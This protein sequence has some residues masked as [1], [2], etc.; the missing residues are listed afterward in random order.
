MEDIIRHSTISGDRNWNFIKAYKQPQCNRGF[1]IICLF[2][3]CIN[4][5]SDVWVVSFYSPLHFR[6]LPEETSED[7]RIKI[8]A[9]IT[10]METAAEMDVKCNENSQPA[11]HKLKSLSEVEEFL[12]M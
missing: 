8:E 9:F 2:H 6:A 4:R 11:I 10:K 1:M 3:G 7:V 12:H 5:N